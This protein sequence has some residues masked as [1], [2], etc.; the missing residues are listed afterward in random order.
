[1]AAKFVTTE[2]QSTEMGDLQIA[3]LSKSGGSVQVLDTYKSPF[4]GNETLATNLMNHQVNELNNQALD[5]S[6]LWRQ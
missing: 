5:T 2:I 1:M 6:I 4:E 3:H